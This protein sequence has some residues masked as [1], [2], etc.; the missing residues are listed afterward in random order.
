MKAAVLPGY[1][2]L[3]AL[4]FP[5]HSFT[6]VPAH[7]SIFTFINLESALTGPTLPGFAFVDLGLPRPPDRRQAARLP[8]ILTT[9]W[10]GPVLCG[11]QKSG[12][13]LLPDSTSTL[14]NGVY[15]SLWQTY[16]SILG[17]IE[18]SLPDGTHASTGVDA[19][20]LGSA[21]STDLTIW[22]FFEIAG[23]QI[24]LPLLALTFICSRTVTRHP[25]VVNVCITWIITGIVSLLLCACDRCFV[26]RIGADAQKFLRWPTIRT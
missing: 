23:N 26:V 8:C 18:M 1:T 4:P 17:R 16:V 22:L 24:L 2:P 15:S 7:P 9:S 20:A 6:V 13:L 11:R 14:Q 3:F 21:A 25:T 5:F 12:P 10:S 19:Q